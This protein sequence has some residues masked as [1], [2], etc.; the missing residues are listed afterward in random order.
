MLPEFESPAPLLG[1]GQ[2]WGCPTLTTYTLQLPCRV[3]VM[4]LF[5]KRHLKSCACLPSSFGCLLGVS[6]S[7][8]L[9][10]SQTGLPGNPSLINNFPVKISPRDLPDGPVVETSP[11]QGVMGWSLV[12]ELRS[13]MRDGQKAKTQNK[14]YCD[15]FHND[16]KHLSWIEVGDSA[17]V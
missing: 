3:R 16:L 5:I 1:L 9:L 13:R 8:V 12:G 7:V 15:I 11:S 6:H 17:S 2:L 10:C 4:L 14:Q